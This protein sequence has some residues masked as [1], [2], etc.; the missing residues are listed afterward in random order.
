[1]KNVI[2]RTALIALVMAVAAGA[3]YLMRERLLAN[4][5]AENSPQVAAPQ[6]G[7]TTSMQSQPPQPT[8][9]GDAGPRREA[10]WQQE[11]GSIS[12]TKSPDAYASWNQRRARIY[13][14]LHDDKEASAANA[15]DAGVPIKKGALSKNYIQA[16]IDDLKPLLKECYDLALAEDH[17]LQGKLTISFSVAAASTGGI[18]ESAHVEEGASATHSLLQECVRETIYTLEL[19]APD[20]GGIVNV[21]YPFSFSH[22]TPQGDAGS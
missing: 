7:E 19:P 14:A 12:I 6:S 5:N 9:A 22:E 1:M 21:R 2:V 10:I 8:S 15:W 20:G 4:Q 18:V 16:A 17:K 11:D 13:E 3:M